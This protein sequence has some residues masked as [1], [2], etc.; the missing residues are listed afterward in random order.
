MKVFW[1]S[2]SFTRAV[3]IIIINMDTVALPSTMGTISF[4]R[5]VRILRLQHSPFFFLFNDSLWIFVLEDN[6]KDMSYPLS[7]NFNLIL[8]R[9]NQERPAPYGRGTWAGSCRMMTG[10]M[11]YVSIYQGILNLAFQENGRKLHNQWYMML[12][13]Q[14]KIFLAISNWRRSFTPCMV[15]LPCDPIILGCST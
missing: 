6:L 12:T 5:Y 10:G 7:T 15:D 4:W 14:W 11:L 9:P 3:I 1:W 13:L 8:I 2:I